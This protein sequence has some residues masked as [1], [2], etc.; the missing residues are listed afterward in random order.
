MIITFNLLQNNHVWV[1]HWNVKKRLCKKKVDDSGQY[2][3]ASCSEQRSIIEKETSNPGYFDAG[4][5]CKRA[6]NTCV[7]CIRCIMSCFPYI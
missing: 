5:I 3:I 6:Q 2:I 1:L 4:Y 7:V